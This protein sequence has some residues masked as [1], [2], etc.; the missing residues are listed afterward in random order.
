MGACEATRYCYRIVLCYRNVRTMLCGHINIYYNITSTV[1]ANN[2]IVVSRR[3]WEKQC[4]IKS[5]KLN[6]QIDHRISEH[7]NTINNE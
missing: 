3:N 1:T 5:Q 6:L 4:A 7:K 2:S